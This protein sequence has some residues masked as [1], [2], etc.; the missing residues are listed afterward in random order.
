M[1]SLINCTISANRAT[2]QG[3][4]I[5]CHLKARPRLGDCIVWDNAVIPPGEPDGEAVCGEVNCCLTEEDPLFI[6]P[7]KFDFTRTVEVQFLGRQ[8][9]QPDFIL[10]PGD[11]GLNGNSPAVDAGC[12]ENPPEVDFTGRSRD[13]GPGI[14]LGPYEFCQD[15]LPPFRRG[16]ANAD[17]Q[18]D[19]SDAAF[20]LSFLFLGGPTPSCV[21]TV[22]LDDNGVPEISDPVFLLNHLFL[23]APRPPDPYAAC[24][25]DPT[26]DSLSCLSSPCKN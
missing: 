24:G 16:D 20:I 26:S 7:G 23:G 6:R 21:K 9:N 17:G 5:N 15:D 10:D 8:A 13:C 1:P 2:F 4:G 3:G 22:D 25:P 19:L 11:Y 18:Q 12:A 14:D